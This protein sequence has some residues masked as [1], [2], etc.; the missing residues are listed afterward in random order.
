MLH[1]FLFEAGHDLSIT[2][3]DHHNQV[4][5]EAVVQNV[6]DHGVCAI[7]EASDKLHKAIMLAKRNEDFCIVTGAKQIKK[8]KEED[9]L[10]AMCFL[11]CNSTLW[12]PKKPLSYTMGTKTRSYPVIVNDSALIAVHFPHV[13]PKSMK[14]VVDKTIYD[15]AVELAV[16]GL[17]SLVCQLQKDAECKAMDRMSF[18]G[19]FNADVTQV[20][21]L[22][23][24]TYESNN[25]LRATCECPKECT[26][27]GPSGTFEYTYDGVVHVRKLAGWEE[28]LETTHK[29]AA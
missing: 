14:E 29:I 23:N 18:A 25:V 2:C 5:A 15:K 8:G 21:Q 19:D 12:R 3:E 4:V 17:H 10:Q 27:V 1:S 11:Y 16:H 20:C 22:F 6:K 26:M 28:H 24:E 7:Q 9:T 13:D